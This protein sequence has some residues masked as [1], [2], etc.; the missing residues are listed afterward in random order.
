MQPYS[1]HSALGKSQFESLF[2]ELFPYLC[3]YA[4]QYVGDADTAQDICQK[5]FIRLW[6]RR[7]DVDPGKSVKAYLFTAVKNRCLNY[8]RDH[9]KYRSRVLDLDCGDFDLFSQEDHLALEELQRRI[10]RAMDALPEK[11]RLVF[12]MSRYRG[13]KYREIADE[14]GIAQKTVEAHMS[15]AIKS[16]RLELKDYQ[17]ILLFLFEWID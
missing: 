12:E 8:L 14:L 16:L 6:E 9:K 2:K 11:C 3:S 15:K 1:L 5:V 10:D 17:L 7:A 13:M 4:Q